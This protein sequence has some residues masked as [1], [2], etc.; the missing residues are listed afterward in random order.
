MPK[1][2]KIENEIKLEDLPIGRI[3][4]Y[5]RYPDCPEYLYVIRICNTQ[6]LRIWPGF[7][8]PQHEPEKKPGM[9]VMFRKHD[10]KHSED[11]PLQLLPENATITLTCNGDWYDPAVQ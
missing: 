11:W 8:H 4:R 6:F 9:A 7:Q 2:Q 1:K 10:I 5:I 3:A